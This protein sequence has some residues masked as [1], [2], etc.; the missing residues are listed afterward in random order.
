MRADVIHDK[1]WPCLPFVFQHDKNIFVG[2]ESTRRRVER[3]SVLPFSHGDS[4]CVGWKL[5]ESYLVFRRPVNGKDATRRNMEGEFIICVKQVDAVG[6]LKIPPGVDVR[7]QLFSTL[8]DRHSAQMT[9][10][11]TYSSQFEVVLQ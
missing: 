3:K 5:E 11:H 8:R 7:L 2:I 9:I 1:V 6:P 4:S 10:H